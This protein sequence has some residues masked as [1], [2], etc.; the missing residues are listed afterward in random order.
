MPTYSSR[1]QKELDDLSQQ[2]AGYGDYKSQYGDQISGLQNTLANRTF[3]YDPE[4]DESYQQYKTDYTRMGEQAMDDTIG[5]VS[6]RTGGLASS[7]A[8]SAA[9]QTYNNYM[10]QLASKIPELRQI[11]YGRFQDEGT[12]LRN[13]LNDYMQR[14]QNAQNIWNNNLSNLINRHKELTDL[15]AQDYAR[16]QYD[17]ELQLA[18]QKAA[19]AASRGGGYGGGS[20]SGKTTQETINPLGDILT[21]QLK[22]GMQ[23]ITMAPNTSRGTSALPLA[24]S[25]FDAWAKNQNTSAIGNFFDQA[26]ESTNTVSQTADNMF[27]GGASKKDIQNML[28]GALNGGLITQMTYDSLLKKYK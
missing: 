16:W 6:A 10:Q 1:Y 17:Q 22:T 23:N 3:E 18:A 20:G 28:A 2:I 25:P 7:Y 19:A 5:K 26:T 24:K 21:P 15:D 12:N 27:R 11:A 4:K 13:Q 9:N 8:T 14:D